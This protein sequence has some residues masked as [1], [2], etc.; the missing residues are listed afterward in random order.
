MSFAARLTRHPIP[1]A[2]ERGAEGWAALQGV[3]AALRP[4]IEGT[5]GSSPYLAGLITKE[6]PWLSKALAEPPE[7]VL[8]DLIAE[9]ATLSPPDLDS[10]LRRIKRRAALIVALAEDLL[11]GLWPLPYGLRSTGPNRRTFPAWPQ[12]LP[13]IVRRRV[14]ARQAAPA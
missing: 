8:R 2:P 5:A 1:H 7:A 12:P 4:L 14:A 10:G 11:G 6:A 13:P 9:T 3:D